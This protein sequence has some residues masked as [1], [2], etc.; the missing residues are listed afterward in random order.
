MQSRSSAPKQIL[1]FTKT[2]Q[3]S[4]SGQKSIAHAGC[5]GLPGTEIIS[6][7]YSKTSLGK[8]ESDLSLTVE[9]STMNIL[10]HPRMDC[11]MYSMAGNSI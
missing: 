1:G 7:A 3:S 8:T 10:G 5:Q 2:R 4:T 11:R 6:R 9:M